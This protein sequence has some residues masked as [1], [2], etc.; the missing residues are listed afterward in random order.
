MVEYVIYK[1]KDLY[2]M[3]LKYNRYKFCLH[4]VERTMDVLSGPRYICQAHNYSLWDCI[5]QLIATLI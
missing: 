5:T 2:V 4:G 3:I 1:I